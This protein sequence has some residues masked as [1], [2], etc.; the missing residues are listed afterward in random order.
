MRI[1]TGT[2]SGPTRVL[3]VCDM[4]W[5]R[6]ILSAKSH[7]RDILSAKSYGPFPSSCF[8]LT[9]NGWAR[10][11]PLST[12]YQP[13]Y[14]SPPPSI[15]TR[16]TPYTKSPP[17]PPVL[18]SRI[19]GLRA[20]CWHPAVPPLCPPSRRGRPAPPPGRTPPVRP[21]PPAAR[22]TPPLPPPPRRRQRLAMQVACWLWGAPA[23]APGP[24]VPDAVGESPV[25][26]GAS[27]KATAIHA[28]P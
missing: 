2:Q 5:R 14:C 23:P 7:G 13:R 28:G 1:T 12:V 24:R 21:Q 15:Q 4:R 25:G 26:W 22:P 3:H 17:P 10:A 18:Q 6:D 16:P 8:S 27:V 9:R 19:I 20:G 11:Y